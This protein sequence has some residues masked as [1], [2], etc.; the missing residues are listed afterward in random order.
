MATPLKIL[1][2]EDS[3]ADA[4]LITAQLRR[5]G[6]EL[7]CTR[8]ETEADFLA[9]LGNAPDIVLSDY[10]MPRFSGMRA[11]QLTKASG[12]DLPFILIS[13]T[14]GEDAAVEAM[15]QGATDY[16]LKDRIARLGGAVTRALEEKRLRDERQRTAEELR[17]Q[18][19]LLEAQLESSLDGILVVDNQGRKILQNRRLEEMWKKS[20]TDG[21][22]RTD[23]ARAAFDPAHKKNPQQFA[24]KVAYLN[25]HPDE[26]SH[27]VIELV[28]GTVLDR[29]SA[30]VRDKAGKNYGRIWSFRDI[31]ERRKLEAQFRQAQKMESIG[32]LAGGIAHDFNNILSAILGNLY[33]AKQDAADQPELLEHLGAISQAAKR[34]TDLVNQILT[35]SRQN[36]QDR[37]PLKL[38][39][40]VLE[41]LKLL[42]AS[43]PAT[44]RIQTDLTDT[45][46]VL[47]NATSVHQ[48]IMNLGTNAWHAMREQPGTLK[49]EMGMIEADVDFAG[50]HPGL[51]PGRYVR[52]A[53]SDTGH[54]MD[55]AT[56]E[57]I[58]DPFFT[59][60]AVG[61][62]T[63][64]GLAV[65]LGIMQSHD[66]AVT[67]YSEP[68]Q[69]TTFHLYFP[70]FETEAAPAENGARAIPRGQGEHILF[71][72]DET[73]LANVGKKMLERLGYTVTSKTSALEAIA[74][75]RNQPDAFRLVVTDLTMPGMDGIK[76]G[77][78]L[79]AV[80]PRLSVILTTGYN[81]VMTEESVR[82]L[83]FRGLLVKP[84]TARAL[85]EAVARALH[86]PAEE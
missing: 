22:S 58:F 45:P 84:T 38:N 53:V 37:E 62:G 64:L 61:E 14:A 23:G 83:G 15:K 48:V 78:Q 79:L 76:L 30:P 31:T 29:Y 85:G 46:T 71:V 12:R 67:V 74:A 68:G 27:D 42:R 18:T 56:L 57:R 72:D 16:L 69:G 47:A 52:L 33:L 9:A 21:A 75:V 59:T 65:V 82:K 40:V 10:A 63:G 35:F 13:G 66:G 49:V 60:K 5:E 20:P 25:A 36:K 86:P 80:Q 50:A 17:Y 34:A 28:D 51:H 39:H 32:M 54:G 41:A 77:T 44:I 2:A 24:Q 7:A 43:V 73:A 81:G 6:F 4:D 8:V 1:I 26:A 55:A 11:A 3:P 19:T 70:V